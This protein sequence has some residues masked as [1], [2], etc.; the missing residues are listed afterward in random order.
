MHKI[1]KTIS[2]PL[3]TKLFLSI[4]A[5][6]Y[7]LDLFLRESYKSSGFFIYI[8]PLRHLLR[9]RHTHKNKRT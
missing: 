5:L 1:K 4:L 9:T 2:L 6:F 8:F 3:C 7:S